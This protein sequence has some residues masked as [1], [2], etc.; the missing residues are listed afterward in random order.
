MVRLPNRSEVV[1]NLEA[2]QI[3]A[4]AV[5]CWNSLLFLEFEH[6]NQEVGEHRVDAPQ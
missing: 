3:F 1:V 4:V 6:H 5:G 2:K